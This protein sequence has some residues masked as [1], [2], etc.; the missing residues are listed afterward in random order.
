MSLALRLP[1]RVVAVIVLLPIRAEQE[2][3]VAREA[4]FVQ[5]A[6][7][8]Q[9]DWWMHHRRIN[10]AAATRLGR[11]IRT[12]S[13][14]PGIDTCPPRRV[15]RLVEFRTGAGNGPTRWA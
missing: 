7:P 3:S 9:R 5:L 8:P 6:A 10:R 14:S 12:A 2:G 1:D 15:G 13:P 11:P 4:C